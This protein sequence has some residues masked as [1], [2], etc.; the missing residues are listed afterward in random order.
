MKLK[1][2]KTIA[3]VLTVAL[4]AVMASC[5]GPANNGGT[6]T[7]PAGG[8][9]DTSK[10]ITL[11]VESAAPLRQNY[12]AL[13]SSE[14]EGSTVYNQ[15]LFTKKL[16]DGFKELYPNIKLQFT[17]DGWGE[18]LYQ[19]QQLHVIA[20]NQGATIDLDLFIGESYMGYFAQNGLFAE[21][22]KEDFAHVEEKTYSSMMVNGKQYGVSVCTGMMGLQYNTQILAEVG[23]PEAEW[24]PATWDQ[25]LENC[26]KVS[27]YAKA[28][29]KNYGGIIM[30]NVSGQS[31]AFRALPFMR[32]AG[33]DLLDDNGNLVLNS[34]E[35]KEAF[36]YLRELSKYA[37]EPSLNVDGEDLLQYY[38]TEK[39]YGAYMIEGQFGMA[40]AGE[41]I[42]SAKLPSK[43]AEGGEGNVVTG[44]VLFGVLN[45]SKNKEAAVAFL[46][47]LTGEEMQKNFYL[48]DGRLPV[49]KAV[50][51]SEEIETVHPNI[52][53]YIEEMRAGRIDE[54]MPCFT[55]N[56][57]DIWS[58]WGTFYKKVLTS[59]EDIGSLTDAAQSDIANKMK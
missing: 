38:F 46:K 11:K 43:T 3:T 36:A 56:T 20:L 54:G 49:N 21:L 17:E 52:N 30:N 35:N 12:K 1:L 53:S 39:G 18:A 32:Q 31:G 33:G 51:N 42:K 25:L 47:Y 8:T 58:A 48:L 15:A 37:Y 40:N 23:I 19:A 16:F 22:N 13:L 50:I 28:N 6:S 55:K 44:N 10:Q 2:F 14:K 57:S 41:H 7:G 34:A 45:Q 27:E 59:S 29:N 9:V 24:V 4:L 26:K 5:G